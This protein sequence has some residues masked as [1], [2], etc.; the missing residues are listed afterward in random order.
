MRRGEDHGSDLVLARYESWRR[1][2]IVSTV[3]AMEGMSALFVN[4]WPL[5]AVLRRGGLRLVDQL[6]AVKS[7]L[8]TEAAGMTGTLP[9]LMRGM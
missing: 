9:R 3:A 2:D 1:F 5:L 6:P 7:V 4:D 8:M